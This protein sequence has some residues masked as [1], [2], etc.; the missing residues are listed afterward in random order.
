M[1]PFATLEEVDSITIT[2]A[3][4]DLDS[5]TIK[6]DKTPDP[7]VNKAIIDCFKK[8]KHAGL[9]SPK[10]RQTPYHTFESQKGITHFNFE[11]N[12]STIEF[13]KRQDCLSINVTQGKVKNARIAFNNDDK[14]RL[15]SN[16]DIVCDSQ[17]I[18]QNQDWHVQLT[19]RKDIFLINYESRSEPH[20]IN[21]YFKT[22]SL[23]TPK[24]ILA[25]SET[26]P[27]EMN[28]LLLTD[29]KGLISIGKNHIKLE[30]YDIL[31]IEDSKD[32]QSKFN[33]DTF[34]LAQDGIII[35]ANGVA[36][37][38]RLNGTQLIRSRLENLFTNPRYFP[39]LATVLIIL[40][41]LIAY[42][43]KKVFH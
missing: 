31:E 27:T 18:S 1:S 19:K 24:H 13:S 35:R 42:V 5:A 2:N 9:G 22:N 7:K 38:I 17:I 40:S 10:Q 11:A 29:A 43:W 15:T 4:L 30:E 16:S 33:L 21:F 25:I 20:M 37:D 26:L 28:K 3:S 34:Q 14:V 41:N 23:T 6:I 39:I 36:A 32:F 8:Y 12:N